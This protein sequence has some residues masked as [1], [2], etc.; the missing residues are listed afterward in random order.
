MVTLGEKARPTVEA[1]FDGPP[2]YGTFGPTLV[3]GRDRYF[4][5]LGHPTSGDPK[6]WENCTGLE[7][8]LRLREAIEPPAPGR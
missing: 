6:L 7:A 5:S 3:G 2:R 8:M 4:A 1:M